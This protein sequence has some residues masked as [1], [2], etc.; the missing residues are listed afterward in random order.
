MGNPRK[1]INIHGH[2][3]GTDDVDALVREWEACRVV[4]FCCQCLGAPWSLA[5]GGE[6]FAADDLLPWMRKY[7]EMIVGFAEVD[8]GSIPSPTSE[9]EKR[10]EQ[11]FSGLK[12]ILPAYRYNDDRYFHL[13]EAAQRLE[14]PIL[15]HTGYVTVTSEEGAG[16]DVDSDRMGTECFDRIARAF[17]GL[18]LIG[19]HFCHSFYHPGQIMAQ[20]HR[21]VYMDMSG[22]SGERPHLSKI[23][24]ALAP[25]P[26][27]DWDD[28]QDNLAI[29]L[30]AKMVFGT[31][32]PPASAWIRSAIEVM[33][34]LHIPEETR[35]LFW[36]RNAARILHLDSI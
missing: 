10:K 30:F 23:K 26:G 28:P 29:G 7:P 31:D 33:D 1:V 2:L 35:E 19:A 21:N 22:G 5:S 14:M 17:P 24:K 16:L 9:V 8:L 25:F 3:H 12:F 36:W 32:N 27:A 20:N 4:R 15:F 6:Y 13:Y 18:V 11:G 34:Y